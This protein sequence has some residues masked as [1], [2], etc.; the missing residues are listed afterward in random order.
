MILPPTYEVSGKLSFNSTEAVAFGGFGD[1]YKGLLGPKNVCIKRLRIS[2]TGD[3]A[4]VKQVFRPQNLR[5]DYRPD[6]P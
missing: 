3:Q 6:R 5:L 1:A 4:L 2:A